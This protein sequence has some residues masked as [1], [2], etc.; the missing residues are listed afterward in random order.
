VGVSKTH[1]LCGKLV[2]VRGSDF[3]SVKVVA[4]D[5]AIAEVVGINDDDVGLLCVARIGS[6][7]EREHHIQEG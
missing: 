2:D 4:L 7:S 6:C 1:P 5:I 3:A